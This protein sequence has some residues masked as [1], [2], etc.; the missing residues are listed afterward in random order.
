MDARRPCQPCGTWTATAV[1]GVVVLL[2]VVEG[3]SV[4]CYTVGRLPLF[5]SDM[6]DLDGD[7][8]RSQFDRKLI[9]RDFCEEA[10][11]K[12]DALVP[13]NRQA[14][15]YTVVTV[16]RVVDEIISVAEEHHADLILLGDAHLRQ[17]RRAFRRTMADRVRRKTSIP[18]VTLNVDD[19]RVGP[20]QEGLGVPV[21]PLASGR[22]DS[23]DPELV[24]AVRGLGGSHR[25]PGV[26]YAPQPHAAAYD[27]PE[28]PTQTHPANLDE[29]GARHVNKRSPALRV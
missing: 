2:H 16:G 13:P 19:L 9:R 8:L 21:Q 12:L 23:H 28:P 17:R 11:W 18:V 10:Q 4:R 29:P 14:C 26:E 5:L 24:G 20:D 3:A 22:A 25:L 15:V 1:G 6:I 27:E 7:F